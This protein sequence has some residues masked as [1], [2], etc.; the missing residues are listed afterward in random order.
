MSGWSFGR[1]VCVALVLMAATPGRLA[2]AATDDPNRV[3]DSQPLE[4]E[5][6]LACTDS[7]NGA[8]VAMNVTISS[9][10][11]NDGGTRTIIPKVVVVESSALPEPA[12]LYLL[13]TSRRKSRPGATVFTVM[14]LPSVKP[15]V[16]LYYGRT[17]SVLDRKLF[18]V[19]V[20]DRDFKCV[21]DPAK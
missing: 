18:Y 16:K 9:D 11:M 10:D 13:R 14:T 2:A 3:I 17:G 12:G 4:E 1:F 15:Q 19:L 7:S 6:S 20:G 5:L 8:S 21:A